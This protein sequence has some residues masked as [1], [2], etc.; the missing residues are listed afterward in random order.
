MMSIENAAK[1]IFQAITE[2]LSLIDVVK[3]GLTNKVHV[4]AT[5]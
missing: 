5:R 3:L 1:E 2:Y 4:F